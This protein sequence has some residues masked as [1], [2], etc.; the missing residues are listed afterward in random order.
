M[1]ESGSDIFPIYTYV[2]MQIH[3]KVAL[4]FPKISTAFK[5]LGIFSIY[6]SHALLCLREYIY[7]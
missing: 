6:Q 5:Y 1:L 4:I 2:Y 7:M 3:W